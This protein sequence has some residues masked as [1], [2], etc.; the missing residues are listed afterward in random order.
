MKKADPR[1]KLLWVLLCTTAALVFTRPWWMMGLSLF[2]IGGV[3][4]FGAD[5][6]A[7]KFRLRRFLPLLLMIALI[8]ALFIGSGRPFLTIRGLV[9]V[10]SDGLLRGITTILRFFVILSAAAVMA[11]EKNRRVIAALNKMG[12]PYLFSFLLT[13]ALRFL[14][15]FGETFSQALIAIQLR[16]VQL[17]KIPL[18]KRLTVYSYLFL[19]VVADSVSK[20]RVLAAVMEARGFGALSRRTYFIEVNMSVWDWVLLGLLLSAGIFAFTCYYLC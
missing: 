3:L 4:F 16:G 18:R 11:A 14:P 9:L 1:V 20:A 19:P 12:V 8:H 10:R 17:K 5:L 13:T 2:T 15:T 6:K 7:L